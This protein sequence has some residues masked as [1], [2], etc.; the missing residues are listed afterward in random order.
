M[1]RCLSSIAVP[2]VWR[3]VRSIALWGGLLG[4]GGCVVRKYQPLSNLHRPVVI[5]PSAANFDD[6]ALTV[7]CVPVGL[8]RGPQA[9][10]LCQ[11]LGTLF[12]N[13]GATVTTLDTV[14]RF[15]ET[16]DAPAE[17]GAEGPAT[18]RHDLILEVRARE[19]HKS[20]HPLSW[21]ATVA[22]FTLVP[23]VYESSFAQDVVIRDGTGF[24]LATDTLEGRVV[25]RYGLGNFLITALADLGRQRDRRLTTGVAD[26]ELSGDLYTQLSQQLFNAKLHWSV[27]QAAAPMEPR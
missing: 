21:V 18:P 1:L 26:R 12:E 15:Q 4:L 9:G 7:H 3:A 6:L 13:Q 22:T 23:A 27:L 16:F 2:T 14:G 17:A 24:L 5:D 10:S 8:L 11:K 20:H 19:T 25:Q